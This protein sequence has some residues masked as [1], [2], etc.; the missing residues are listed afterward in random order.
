MGQ[1]CCEI[2]LVKPGG[3]HAQWWERRIDG[4][5]ID[6]SI[7]A[8]ANYEHLYDRSFEDKKRV[9]VAGHRR[10]PVSPPR[11][12]RADAPRTRTEWPSRGP[13]TK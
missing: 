2:Q 7:A 8:K 3:F 4:S 5:G 12:G 10:E 9:R 13:C 11:H 1:Q 6:A